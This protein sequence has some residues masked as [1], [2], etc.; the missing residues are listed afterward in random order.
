MPRVTTNQTN[1]TSGEVS[2]K[3]YGRVDIARYQ[4]G[5]AAMP[6]CVVDVYGGANRRDGQ[7]FIAP[8][9]D[10]TKKSRLIPYIFNTTQA[11]ML[12]FGDLYMRVYVQSGGQV[13]VGPT[14][15]EIATPYT[16]AMLSSLDYTQG[17][18]TMFLFHP[19]VPIQVLHRIASD[20]WTIGPAP[21]TVEPFDEIGHTFPVILTLSNATVGTGRTAT[22]PSATFLASDVG[23][24]IAYQSGLALITG[25]TSSTSVTVTVQVAFSGVSLP[26]S[27]WELLDSPQTT[28]TPS[29]K[30]PVGAAITL[31]AAAD[32]WRT[33]DVGKFVRINGGMVQITAGGTATVANAVIKE[34]LDSVVAAPA[35]AWSLESSVWN[36]NNGY[37]STG[38]LYEQR[39]TV[40]GSP[41]YPQTVWGSRSGLF[42]DFTIGTNDDDAFSFA[43]PS[44][45]QINPI[46]RM[47]TAKSL[48]PLTYGGE[49]TMEGGNDLPLTPTNVKSRAPSVY[50]CNNVKPLRIGNEIMFVQRAGRKIRSLAFSI[51]TDTYTAPNIAVLAEHITVSGIVDMAYQQEPNSTLWCVRADGKIAALTIDRDEGVIAWTPLNTDGLYESVASI[52]NATGDE[53]WMIVHRTINGVQKRYVERFDTSLYTDCAITG[54]DVVG[55]KIWTGIDHL[56]GKSVAVK[57]DGTYVGMFTVTAGAITLL[58]NARAVEIGLPFSNSV[59]LLRPELQGGEGSAQANPQRIHEVSMLLADTIGCTINGDVIAFREFGED[60][61]DVPPQ[62]FSGYKR[63]GLTEW[64]RGDQN[65]TISQDEPYPFHL[66]SVV[67]K[68]TVNS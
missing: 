59:K 28:V 34:E 61:L 10:S 39:L 21:I 68:L 32:A 62:Q 36:A 16:E 55:K 65:V 30:D 24:R 14:P 43:L 13:L 56:E 3:C 4:N 29:A 5:A 35:N 37:P 8:T 7:R 50:G 64:T 31:T 18:D 40:A 52:P 47:V 1:F 42:Y 20:Y 12:E 58:R 44:T 49:F 63:A 53:T 17:A 25:F 48:F 6:N 19:A 57:A 23:R 15:Y 46:Q 41:R 54:T 66:L 22:V 67:R 11:Y 2:P 27:A 38:A 45:G 9:K 60:L 51:T 26:A 33:V